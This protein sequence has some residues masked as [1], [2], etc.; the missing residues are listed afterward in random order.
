[1]RDSIL[2]LVFMHMCS[3]AHRDITPSKIIK[4]T[5]NRYVLT[6]FGEGTNLTYQEQ[7]SYWHFY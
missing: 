5:E 4:M 7:Y 6:D 1:M 3:I 2:G